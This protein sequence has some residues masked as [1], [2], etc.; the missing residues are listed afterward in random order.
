MAFDTTELREQREKTLVDSRA[1]I[2]K[3]DEET[4]ALSAEERSQY[5]KL[6]KDAEKLNGEIEDHERRN[7]LEQAEEEQRLRQQ[8]A[9]ARKESEKEEQRVRLPLRTG[10]EDVEVRST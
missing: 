9:D 5:D 7:R 3:A 10:D 8:D 1:L 6:W 4:R 2:D